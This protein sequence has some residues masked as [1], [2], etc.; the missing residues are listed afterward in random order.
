MSHSSLNHR[1]YGA[2]LISDAFVVALHDMANLKI[3]LALFVNGIYIQPGAN[4]LGLILVFS[5]MCCCLYL[6]NE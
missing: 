4:L 1:L 5:L 2:N 6:H 3:V